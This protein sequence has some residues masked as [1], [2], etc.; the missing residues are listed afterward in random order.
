MPVDYASVVLHFSTLGSAYRCLRLVLASY[1]CKT[2]KQ[3]IHKFPTAALKHATKTGYY[4]LCNALRGCDHGARV[5]GFCF[6]NCF[7]FTC[8]QSQVQKRRPLQ[9]RAVSI[10][11]AECLPAAVYDPKVHVSLALSSNI[12]AADRAGPSQGLCSCQQGC[13]LASAA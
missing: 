5:A 6:Y 7:W 8:G 4:E 3:R 2:R 13:I 9:I 11:Y 10:Y 1:R 12:V